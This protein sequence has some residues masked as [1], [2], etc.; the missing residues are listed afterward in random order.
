MEDRWINIVTLKIL[1]GIKEAELVELVLQKIITPYYKHTDG[2]YYPMPFKTKYYSQEW[3]DNYITGRP[4]RY[5]VENYRDPTKE[6]IAGQL[7]ICIWFRQ[8]E[9]D[10]AIYEGK[11]ILP[12]KPQGEKKITSL[13]Q[14]GRKG[15]GARKRNPAFIEA[16]HKY[17]NDNKKRKLHWSDEEI[18]RDFCR[19]Y[20]GESK[21]CNVT[22]NGQPWEVFS[23][24]NL[25]FARSGK[26]KDKSI[27][28]STL[29]KYI[30]EVKNSILQQES[31]N[32][33]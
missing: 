8:I 19:I 13:S 9:I 1:L 17:F 15:G 6:E 24:D 3:R 5:N 29:R 11:L 7:K 16:L 31:V 32:P 27:K 28:S 33:S 18:C 2:K 20:K 14:A 25:I 26:K 23:Y 4:Y 12:E 22:V 21:P 10:D 30:S